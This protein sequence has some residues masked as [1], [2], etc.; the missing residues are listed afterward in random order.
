MRGYYYFQS[1][2]ILPLLLLI[3]TLLCIYFKAFTIDKREHF[4][5][6]KG[7]TWQIENRT[8]KEDWIER[9][10]QKFLL[11]NRLRTL[12]MNHD[13][14]FNCN[15]FITIVFFLFSFCLWNVLRKKMFISNYKNC[16]VRCSYFSSLFY[17]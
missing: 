14:T 4:P 17:C 5:H 2:S 16:I 12:F 1:S 6:T 15:Q 9:N 3:L 8:K 11:L 7:T 10:W 13:F